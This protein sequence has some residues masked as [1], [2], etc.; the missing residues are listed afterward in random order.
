MWVNIFLGFLTIVWIWFCISNFVATRTRRHLINHW[1]HSGSD[2]YAHKEF[3]LVTCNQHFWRV[4][5]FRSAKFLY[6]PLTQGIWNHT[7]NN[8]NTH[9]EHWWRCYLEIYLKLDP[10]GE[11]NRTVRDYLFRGNSLP[12]ALER[13]GID[14]YAWFETLDEQKEGK[15][16]SPMIA[17]AEEYDQVMAVQEIMECP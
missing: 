14:V 8:M 5:T 6:G 3:D 16:I 17:G 2:I 9:N 10:D 12:S 11:I 13:A 7:G 1:G 15:N 4:F